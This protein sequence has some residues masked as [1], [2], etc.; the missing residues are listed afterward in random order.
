MNLIEEVEKDIKTGNGYQND[1]IATTNHRLKVNV[2]AVSELL[3]SQESTRKALISLEG[4][5]KDLDVKNG[6]L[7]KVFLV[8]TIVATIFTILQVVQVVDILLKWAKP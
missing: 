3:K 7:Q 6:R 2:M 4:T 8:L 1:L 5:I